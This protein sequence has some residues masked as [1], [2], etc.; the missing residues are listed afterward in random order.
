M[1]GE[2][3]D[4]YGQREQRGLNAHVN[5]SFWRGALWH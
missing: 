5:V 1:A 3:D 4:Q 2:P